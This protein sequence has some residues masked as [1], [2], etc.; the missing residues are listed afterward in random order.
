MTLC[1]PVPRPPNRDDFRRSQLR[2][3]NALYRHLSLIMLSRRLRR[4]LQMHLTRAHMAA[5]KH[6]PRGVT[7]LDMRALNMTYK[8]SI[9]ANLTIY[10]EIK[11]QICLNV[12]FAHINHKLVRAI[13]LIWKKSIRC[14][15]AERRD[16]AE[17]TI[18]R[19]TSPRCIILSSTHQPTKIGTIMFARS[20]AGVVDFANASLRAGARG[21]LTFGDTSQRDKTCHNGIRTL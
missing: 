15:S 4:N 11:Q 14:Q 19:T 21:S 3:L 20:P 16:S 2:P 13:W 7:G 6:S 9:I 17:V 8:R 12:C 18:S 1:R 5:T 10:Q